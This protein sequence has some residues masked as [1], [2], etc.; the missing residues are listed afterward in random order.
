MVRKFIHNLLLR[1]HFWRY[2]TFSEVAELYAS[3]V[4]RMAAFYIMGT[5]VSIYIYQIGYSIAAIGFIW[6]AFYFFKAFVA[7]PITRLIAWIGPKHAILI[8]NILFIPAMVCFALLPTVGSW[9]LI[10]TFMLQA[11]STVMY[12]VAHSINFSK[13]KSVD[14]AGKEIAYMNIL[15]KVTIGVSPLIGGFI[16]F[17]WGPQTTMVVAALLFAVAAVPLLATGE[18]VRINQKLVLRGFPWRLFLR[19]APAQFAYGMDVFVS[20]TAWALYVAIFI[21]SISAN[22][23]GV[24][25]IIGVLASVVL[26]VAVIA[27]Y[28]FGKLVDGRRGYE[29][30]KFGAFV[31]AATHLV[32]PFVISP[33]VVVGVNATNEFATTA[34]M[35]PYTRGIFDNA[36]ISGA[37]ITYMGLAE[38][39]ANIGAGVGALLLGVVALMTNGQFALQSSFFIAAIAVLFIASAR[40]PLYKK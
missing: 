23:D 5:F 38:V 3:R 21:L 28:A 18:Q 34:Y 16:A 20:G 36:D 29:L 14:H 32:R 35:L 8:S 11:L 12:A 24:Y 30:M 25:A 6:A 22:G 4:L 1:R 31:N 37:R 26:V 10:P 7:L 13:V 40:F 27:S 17:L 19:H 15:E 9:L 2:A 33:V 39:L